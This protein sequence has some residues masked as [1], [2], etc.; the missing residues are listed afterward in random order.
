MNVARTPSLMVLIEV[1]VESERWR[2]VGYR[3]LLSSVV[4]SALF[5]GFSL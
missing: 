3:S 5:R 4:S 2:V 1:E